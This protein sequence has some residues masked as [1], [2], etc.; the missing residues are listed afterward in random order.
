M[1]E[2]LSPVAVLTARPTLAADIIIA[3]APDP[4][5]VCDLEGKILEANEAVSRLLGLRRDE[6]LEQSISRFLGQDEAREFVVALRE[7]VERDV[8]RNVR[9]Q[10]RSASGEMIPTTLNASALRDTDGN[11]IGAIGILRDMR[12]LDHARAY[13]ESLIKNAPDPVFVSDL[14]GKIHQANDA[15]FSLLGFRPDELIEQSLSRIISPEET[16]EFMVALR[17][18]VDRGVTRNARLHPRSAS[19][20]V[21]PTTLNASALRDTEGRVI[22][23]IGILRDMRELDKARAYAESLIKNAPDPVFVSDLEGKILQAND[24]VSHLLGFRQDEVVEQSVSRFLG[25]DETR[26]FVAALREVVE[27]GVSRNVRLHPRSASGEVISTTLNASALRDADGN[28]IGA[29]G[30]LR[31]M[32]AYEQ[33][34]HDLEDSRRELRDADQAKDRFLAIVSHELRTPLTAMLGWVRLLTTGRLDDA[35]SARALPVIERNTK[36]LAQLIDDLLDVSGIIAGKLRLEVGPVDLVAVIE[37]AIEA[38]QGLADAKSIGLKAVLDP[39]AGSVAGDPGRLQQVVWNLLA[40]AIKFTP[41]RGRIDLRLE[42]AGSHARLTVRDTGRGISP[43]LLP[44]I[45]DR[46]RQDERTRQ[47]GGLGLGLA[48]VRHIVKLHEGNVWAESDGEGRGA[49]LVVEL[50]LPI[51]DVSP[52]AKPAIVY[53]R[54]E[55]ASSRLIN[56]AGRRILVVDDEADARDLLAQILGQAGADVIVVGSADEALETLRRWRPDVL[57]SDIGMPGDDGYVLIRKVRALGTAEGGQVRALALTAYARSE[58]RALALE[59][60]FHTHIAKPV[61][62]LELTA[63]IA[64][65]APERRD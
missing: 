11:I 16:W 48:I 54:L 5:F 62:P 18:V 12:E 2:A 55:S 13:A 61:D 10:P 40:N 50:P 43:E 53:R 7:V 32:R 27:H 64:G 3:N 51:E 8:T 36:L 33:V 58:D 6:V 22:G 4:V 42:R 14:E 31:D 52:A 39:S 9:L 45:F 34:L 15:V 60:G 59:A 65:L 41:N 24:A 63:L 57:V 28:V 23:A 19:G 25:A 21:I 38:V 17:E 1:P 20:D 56:L 29:I 46:F 47:H 49:T 26:E 37:S 35:T 44:H 30:I